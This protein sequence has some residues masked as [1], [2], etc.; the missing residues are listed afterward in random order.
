MDNLMP[1]NNSLSFKIETQDGSIF[2][3]ELSLFEYIVVSL[4]ILL[5]LFLYFIFNR[6]SA[7]RFKF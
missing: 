4:I 5:F 2:L 7:A 3:N 1:I 6:P